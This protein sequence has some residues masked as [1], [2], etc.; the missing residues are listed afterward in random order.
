L[1]SNIAIGI[2]AKR[3]GTIPNKTLN[4]LHGKIYAM[5]ALAIVLL[6]WLY[7][8]A[9]Q[10]LVGLFYPILGINISIQN[11][12]II[13]SL[14]GIGLGL[15]FYA[16]SLLK[17]KVNGYVIIGGSILIPILMIST[18]L[19]I[20][21]SAFLA[22]MIFL[23]KMG[24]VLVICTMP[25]VGCYGLF[26]KQ[27]GTFLAAGVG[28]LFFFFFTKILSV[29]MLGKVMFPLDQIEL[30]ILFFISYICFLEMGVTS[31][32]FDHMINKMTPN[33]DTDEIVLSRF[34]RLFNR[35]ILH[36]SFVLILCYTFALIIFRYNNYITSL[37][38]K[39][40]INVDISSVQGMLL[41][42]IFTLAGAFIFWFLI[43]REKTKKV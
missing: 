3:G 7:A 27:K 26:K 25:I 38:P 35:Y 16:V 29:I 11:L 33:E 41:L 10:G 4:I 1:E 34:N 28:I 6:I 5:R 21:L 36:V 9:I 37:I 31:I 14:I 40:I 8:V 43:P 17:T 20:G 32:N 42:V 24:L 39:E 23:I 2:I 13:L 19:I 22:L 12:T 18:Y 15:I 30:I